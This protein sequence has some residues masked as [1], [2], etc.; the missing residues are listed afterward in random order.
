M[1]K[2][3]KYDVKPNLNNNLLPWW[4]KVVTETH[5]DN[6]RVLKSR[7]MFTK[8]RFKVAASESLL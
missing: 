1:A 6:F 5:S 2:C 3:L 4:R 8:Q 7:C